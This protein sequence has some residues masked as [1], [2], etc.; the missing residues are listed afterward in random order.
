MWRPTLT[1]GGTATFDG[2]GAAVTLDGSLT[3]SDVDSGGLLTSGTV[4]IAGFV[5]GDI[6]SASANEAAITAAYN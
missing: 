3:V 5:A 6:L 1:A 2:G 4:S